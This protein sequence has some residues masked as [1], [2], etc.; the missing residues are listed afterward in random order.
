MKPSLV[1]NVAFALLMPVLAAADVESK[2]SPELAEALRGAA[3]PQRLRVHIEFPALLAP[4]QLARLA[5][6]AS[7]KAAGRAAVVGVLQATAA[8]SQA[9]A[10]AWLREQAAAG[11]VDQ[12]RPLWIINAVSAAATPDVIR[13]LAA[14]TDVQR[15]SLDAVIGDRMFAGVETAGGTVPASE[16][17]SCEA[18]G[19]TIPGG[20]AA[21][22][23]MDC[24]LATMQTPR[25]W[26]EFGLY[27]HGVKVAMIDSG[28]CVFHPDYE[29]QIWVNPGEIPNNGI[30]DDHN[31][32]IDDVHGWNFG[33]NN[34]NIEDVL[35]HGTHIA[36]TIAGDG[37][38]GT[39]TGL[40]PRCQLG[41]LR[42]SAQ[43][44]GEAEVWNAMQYAVAMDFD[45]INGSIGWPL[46]YNPNRAMW[47][48]VCENT[49]AAGMILICAAG[50]EGDAGQCAGANATI[51]CPGDVPGVITV[52]ATDCG[53]VIWNG[54]SRGN[55]TWVGV[56]GYD[57]WP[58]PPGYLKPT[59]TAPGAGVK[60]TWV[61]NCR[62]YLVTDGTSCA[63]PHVSGCVALML[64]AN[65]SLTHAQVR[66]IL[67]DTSVD[68]GTPGPDRHYGAGRVDCY[69]AVKKARAMAG[70]KGDLNCS[71][72]V[73][74][75]DINPFV[76]ALADPAGYQA[77]FPNCN[78]M[79]GDCNNDGAVDFEDIN[80]FVAL[81]TGS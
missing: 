23:D 32:F 81:L 14:R 61:T 3:P 70:R 2:L 56:P 80:A 53:D 58:C 20:A 4:E 52:G 30:D 35:Y 50:N 41:V 64:E 22:P 39:Q 25:V 26:A 31:G 62:D 59:I 17:L 77:Q 78:I 1:V 76:L 15:I 33:D 54:S 68:L 24:G 57:D 43:L 18:P 37:T 75:D 67:E 46:M 36:G 6:S 29:H 51:R 9:D 21:L 63:T 47:R 66:Q 11:H 48:Q 28:V 65:P 34:N 12:I 19:T 45:L 5:G 38:N 69:E 74:F 27:G 7:D 44:S 10:L 16:A 73:D 13:A 60:S 55:V 79:N 8:S 40:A 71:G 42:I 72:A 49:I